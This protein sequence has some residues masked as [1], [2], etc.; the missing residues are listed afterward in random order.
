MMGNQIV[1]RIYK[2]QKKIS[3]IKQN[4]QSKDLSFNKIML[5][6]QCKVIKR[7]FQ[8]IQHQYFRLTPK[9][10]GLVFQGYLKLF[11]FNFFEHFDNQINCIVNNFQFSQILLFAM[12]QNNIMKQQ[13]Q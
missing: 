11:L 1:R 7:V 4:S 2:S 6:P 3:Q 5:L 10:Q 8:D 12:N 13:L 9:N